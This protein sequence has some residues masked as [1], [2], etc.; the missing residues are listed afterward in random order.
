MK[1]RFTGIL[2]VLVAATAILTGCSASAGT[3]TAKDGEGSGGEGSE[4]SVVTTVGPDSGT[5]MNMWSFVEL[6]NTFYGS[7]VERWNE[8]NPDRQIQVLT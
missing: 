4:A 3:D 6:H 2:A 8:E 7:M 5:H 1:R